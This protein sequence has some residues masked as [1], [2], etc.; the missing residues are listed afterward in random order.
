MSEVFRVYLFDRV[1][2]KGI[3]CMLEQGQ[4]VEVAGV[5]YIKTCEGW[6]QPRREGWHDTPEAAW[7]AAAE[8][9]DTKIERLE[10]QRDRWLE[11]TA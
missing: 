8:L 4:A 10:Q 1:S 11:G 3:R 7:K 9:L 6:L 2:D 5:K